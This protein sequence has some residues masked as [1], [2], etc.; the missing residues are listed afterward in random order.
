MSEERLLAAAAATV[1]WVIIGAVLFGTTTLASSFELAVS[2]PFF[3]LSSLL[4]VWLL[5]GAIL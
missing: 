5:T 1:W 2:G 3:D 4:D